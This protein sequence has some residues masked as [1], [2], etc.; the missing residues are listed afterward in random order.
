M[1][2]KILT[3]VLVPA[4]SASCLFSC[5]QYVTGTIYF[6]LNGGSFPESFGVT[7]LTGK[8]GEKIEV[9][10]P[11]PTYDGYYFVGWYEKNAD[12]EYRSIHTYLDDNGN[13]YY[14]YPYGTDTWYAY[15]EP[16][17]TIT[18]DLTEG[19]DRNGQIIAPSLS[20]SDFSGNVLNGY[21]TKSIPSESYLPTATADYLYFDYWYTEYPLIAAE[22]ENGVTHYVYDM[23]EEKGQYEFATQFG[24]DGMSFPDIDGLTLYAA[25]TEYPR[26]TVH[27]GIE[28][29]PD[30]SFQ[31]AIGECIGDYL[32]PAFE[33]STGL[34]LNA[35]GYKYYPSTTQENRFAGFYLNEEYTQSFGLETEV[36]N[37]DIDLYVK[38]DRLIT[39]ELDYN[40]GSLNGETGH[41]FTTYYTG[42]V[43]GNDLYDSYKP[44]KQYATF[45][46]YLGPD[47]EV[48][49]FSTDELYAPSGSDVLVLTAAYDD[50]P[51]ID[52]E[53]VWPENY[54]QDNIDKFN[55][56]YGEK[57]DLCEIRQPG[58]S[59]ISDFYA[60]ID[61]DIQSVDDTICVEDFEVSYDNG[62]TWSTH[63]I[64]TMPDDDCLMKIEVAYKM[65]IDVVTTIGRYVEV[66]TTENGKTTKSYEIQEISETRE[67]TIYL[68]AGVSQEDTTI[69]EYDDDGNIIEVMTTITSWNKEILYPD[70]ERISGTDSVYSDES[71][72]YF[73]DG[74]Y[75]NRNEVVTD[76][77]Q[78]T[79]YEYSGPYVSMAADLST[80]A[81]VEEELYRLYLKGITLTFVDESGK[82][83]GQ[84]VCKPHPEIDDEFK[85]SVLTALGIESYTSL[86]IDGY[87]LITYGPYV[88]STVTVII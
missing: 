1:N 76:D 49:N 77:S 62:D 80:Q 51:T 83:L 19:A 75:I 44:E 23:T 47:G 86:Q 67:N 82:T 85:Q 13:E 2:K 58:G 50:Y 74:V 71:G 39:V 87:N 15:F 24:T 22:D 42:D 46:Y 41:E 81:P 72:T 16:L 43:L 29:I 30:F 55:Q 53:I 33:E 21:V 60:T 64:S 35:E 68:G 48:F 8:A 88:D 65:Q 52:Y 56:T 3:A 38:W 78:N 18:F 6:V 20:S 31:L 37:Q 7:S 28:E 57:N 5:N 4:I 36:Y 54:S 66:E 27:T 12:G 10:I 26:V 17:S 73:R 69:Y 25:W 32:V 9:T 63:T 11:D 34:N 40:G 59:D 14:P 61:A 84:L 70:D 79:Y 45:Q